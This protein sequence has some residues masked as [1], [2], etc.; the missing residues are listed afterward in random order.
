MFMVKRF[1]RVVTYRKD[2]LPTNS[3]EPSIRCSGK[4]REKLNKLYLYLQK[5]HGHQTKKVA[6][7]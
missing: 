1:I 4:V 5:T 7:L 2:L 3:H 6:D